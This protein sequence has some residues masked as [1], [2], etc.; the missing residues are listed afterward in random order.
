MIRLSFWSSLNKENDSIN[1]YS[2][3]KI[4]KG[5]SRELFYKLY[6]VKRKLLEYVIKIQI[7][8]WNTV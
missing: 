2:M 7:V 5:I 1:N 6:S 4:L 3:Q 8:I